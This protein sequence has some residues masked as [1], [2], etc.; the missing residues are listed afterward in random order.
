MNTYYGQQDPC[1]TMMVGDTLDTKGYGVA[2]YVNHNLRYV[3]FIILFSVI[4][5]PVR[6][7][8]VS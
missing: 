6:L 5:R 1:D 3:P 2:T 8:L 7:A 4:V